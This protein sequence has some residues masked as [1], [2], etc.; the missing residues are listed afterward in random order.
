MPPNPSLARA[1][2]TAVFR[3][4][5]PSRRKRAMLRDALTRNHRAYTKLLAALLPNVE[6]YASAKVGIKRESAISLDAVPIVRPLPLSI[7]A[8][9]GLVSDVAGQ[10]S[11]F[12]E[13]REKQEALSTPTAARLNATQLDYEASLLAFVRATTVEE[14]NT[15]RDRLFS[16]VR[17]G[18]RRPILFLKN[19]KAD[20]FLILFS[21]KKG[22]YY[23][24][25]NLHPQ[26]SR[27]AQAV[28]VD[29]LVDI[30]SGEPVSF[31]SK[32]GGLFPVEFGCDFHLARFIRQGRPQSA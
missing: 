13:L 29:G 21:E 10:I 17:A 6:K 23:V 12:I 9:A 1:Y 22:D 4:H 2:K 32:T 19:R 31:S 11:S 8:K 28:R 18:S 15:A 30:R 24:W 16:E 3:I 27:F 7:G 26:D 5:N 20:G 25:L 14:E